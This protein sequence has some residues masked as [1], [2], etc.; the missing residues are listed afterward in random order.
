MYIRSAIIILAASLLPLTAT[1][2]SADDPIAP[3]T[4]RPNENIISAPSISQPRAV[5]APAIQTPQGVEP[6]RVQPQQIERPNAIQTTP[7]APARIE[8]RHNIQPTL[9]LRRPKVR[10]NKFSQ[11]RHNQKA[12]PV[13]R[14]LGRRA[15]APMPNGK[16]MKTYG[17][18]SFLDG[19]YVDEG[20]SYYPDMDKNEWIFLPVEYR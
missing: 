1:G 17:V 15:P 2:Q 20:E 18:K 13:K 10:P 16:K 5:D 3:D 6:S 9:N 8:N 19:Y 4:I 11:R 14:K 12:R 7:V